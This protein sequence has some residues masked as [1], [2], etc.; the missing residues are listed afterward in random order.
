MLCDDK[1][2]RRLHDNGEL[3]A[4][5]PKPERHCYPTTL[6]D[7]INTVREAED[8]TG[9]KPEVRACGSHWAL[10]HAAV[11]DGFLVE[12]RN[13]EVD[14]Q[15][16]PARLNKMNKTLYEVFPKC[17]TSD[18]WHFFGDQGVT[19]YKD[20]DPLD[21][22]KFYLYH[23]EAGTTIWELYSRLDKGEED[24]GPSI[25]GELK[26]YLGPWAMSTL[27]GAGG[28]TIVGAISTGTHGG[29]V[30]LPPI[31]DAVQAVH[32]IGPQGQQFWIEREL[33]PGIQLVN[34]ALLQN[35]YGDIMVIR[36]AEMLNSVI[37]AAGRMGIIYSVVLRVVRQYALHQT[38]LKE[39]WSSVKQ[40][41]NN[42]NHPN[43]SN[44]RFV[45]IVMSPNSQVKNTSEHTCIII[46][47][48]AL[49]L[50]VAGSPPSGPS[51]R[52][53]RGSPSTAGNSHAYG[54]KEFMNIICNSDAPIKAA[55]Q[56]FIK[57]LE[58][59]RNTALL[60]AAAAVAV[61]INP[62]TPPGVREVA[63]AAVI[64]A[65]AVAA[66]AQALIMALKSFLAIAPS[67][68]LGKTLTA[69]CNWATENDL[70]EVIRRINEYL[71]ESEMD[72]KKV[73]TAISYALM[74]GTNYKNVGCQFP[75]DSLEAFFDHTDPNLVV[76]ID[77]IIQRVNELESGK[78]TGKPL[79][80]GGWVA[81]RFMSQSSALIAMQKFPRT[82]SVEIAMPV[83]ILGTEPFMQLIE[84]DAIELGATLHWGQ[85]NNMNMKDVERLFDATG[86]LFRWRKALSKISSNGRFAT[87]STKFTRDRGL[88]V[89]QPLVQ[90]FSV[91]PRF[92]CAGS[93]LRINWNA[94]N[95]PPGTVASLEVGTQ[96]TS[97]FE[98]VRLPALSGSDDQLVK[99]PC[100]HQRHQTR[101]SLYVKWTYFKG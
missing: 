19:P 15:G 89:V 47:R 28:Q 8:I 9:P 42:P 48:N 81:L 46:L 86:P 74:D 80:I 67:G 68:P 95:N 21:H 4:I 92:A 75:G 49:P 71:I 29:D 30:H 13:P 51:G 1:E 24:P 59:I 100:R 27:G 87:F 37:V 16:N 31:A 91:V 7:L 72:P 70:F 101:R 32:L 84:R 36:D 60:T 52:A 26:Q 50:A 43:F 77:R 6:Q 82:C 2:W 39:N 23:V 88:E 3:P 98:S 38:G 56:E 41:L 25:A 62:F 53:E 73:Y 93:Q 14:D 90:D 34:E 5:V 18:A 94:N 55:I 33:A 45:N 79:A 65:L 76:F 97:D 22:S 57:E 58:G 99:L 11:T 40:W 44:N 63:A 54:S 69:I 85:R 20:S 96:G 64:A 66:V 83:E 35:L 61:F 10:S 78:I 17:M 12:T